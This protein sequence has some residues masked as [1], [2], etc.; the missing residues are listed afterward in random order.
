MEDCQKK[1]EVNE[2]VNI[3]VKNMKGDVMFYCVNYIDT[4]NLFRTT[5]LILDRIMILGK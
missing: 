4:G 3:T 5:S 2:T 1:L